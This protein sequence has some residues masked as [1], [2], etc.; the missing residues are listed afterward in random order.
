MIVDNADCTLKIDQ[1]F[2]F[3]AVDDE[4]NEGVCGC[5]LPDGT[6]TAMVGADMKRIESLMPIAKELAK[7]CPDKTIRLCVFKNREEIKQIT[8]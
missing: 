4:G 6:L 5:T 1:L 7:R 3:I 8:G 2:A